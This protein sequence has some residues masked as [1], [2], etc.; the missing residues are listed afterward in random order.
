MEKG[1]EFSGIEGRRAGIAAT[2][3]PGAVTAAIVDIVHVEATRPTGIFLSGDHSAARDE[4]W[5]AGA[6]G[7]RAVAAMERKREEGK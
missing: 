4:S 6:F 1:A 7:G 5:R 3:R 2:A